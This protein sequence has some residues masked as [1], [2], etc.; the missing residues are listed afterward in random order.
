MGELNILPKNGFN[1]QEDA[2]PLKIEFLQMCKTE[3]KCR[4]SAIFTVKCKIT[5]KND[6]QS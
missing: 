1:G 4:F 5:S 6:A 3:P 2:T